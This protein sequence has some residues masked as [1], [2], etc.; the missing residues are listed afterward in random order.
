MDLVSGDPDV[1]VGDE[2]CLALGIGTDTESVAPPPAPAPAPAPAPTPAPA[3]ASK[4]RRPRRR[5]PAPATRFIVDDEPATKGTVEAVVN[6]D[7]A[8]MAELKK[9]VR[10]EVSRQLPEKISQSLKAA[11]APG[12]EV[13]DCVDAV[14]GKLWGEFQEENTKW[15]SSMEGGTV[16]ARKNMI[17]RDEVTAAVQDLQRKIASAQGAAA[18]ASMAASDAAAASKRNAVIPVASSLVKGDSERLDKLEAKMVATSSDVRQLKRRADAASSSSTAD[19]LGAIEKR[20]MKLES[21]RTEQARACA[22]CMSKVEAA[23]K[24]LSSRIETIQQSIAALGKP[25]PTKSAP[26]DPHLYQSSSTTSASTKV[27]PAKPAPAKSAPAK[28]TPAKPATKS[29]SSKVAPVKSSPTKPAPAPAKIAV[30]TPS[31]SPLGPATPI[32][33]LEEQR[34]RLKEHMARAGLTPSP[35]RSSP[36]SVP[37]AAPAE[38]RL[39]VAP[40]AAPGRMSLE[41][42]KAILDDHMARSTSAPAPAPAPAPVQRRFSRFSAAGAKR[43][44][45]RVRRF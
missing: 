25:A 21:S 39:V 34:R 38:R 35:V 30:T 41:Q 36:T 31:G 13:R 18:A 42:Q 27:T 16:S 29:T 24:A 28:A 17:T 8:T 40:P 9:F 19:A 10:E 33:P 15:R 20:I 45:P 1:M 23:S 7:S 5:A 37:P 11:L 26:A 4:P 32:M 43:P 3:K 44:G 12:G 22:Q 2:D 14:V 6:I